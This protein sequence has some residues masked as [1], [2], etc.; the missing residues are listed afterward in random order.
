MENPNVETINPLSESDSPKKKQS[1]EQTEHQDHSHV[2]QPIPNSTPP[3]NNPTR[4]IALFNEALQ[5]FL[6]LQ[7]EIA[8]IEAEVKVRKCKLK[9]LSATLMS[10]IKLHNIK[11]IKLEGGADN[12]LSLY[13]EELNEMKKTKQKSTSKSKA[14]SKANSNNSKQS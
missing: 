11:D 12:P 9:E 4:D 10:Y 7:K 1:P 3:I 5:S 2:E 6:A 13:T 14:D 8:E